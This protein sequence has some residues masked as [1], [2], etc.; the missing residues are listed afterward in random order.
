MTGIRYFVL[1]QSSAP[2]PPAA[3]LSPQQARDQ[4]REQ[5]RQSVEDGVR[6]SQ[7]GAR[8]GEIVRIGPDGH[9]TVTPRQGPP[10]TIEPDHP[11]TFGGPGDGIPPEA[12]DMAMGFF[13]MCAV[14]VVG[15]PIARAFGRRIE[16]SATTPAIQPEVAA[17]LH[18]IEQAVES[19]A[20][21]VERISESQRFV[22]KL[23]SGAQAERV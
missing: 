10:M 14:M 22:A 8:A 18:R 6:A 20:I 19:M 17:Q 9:V 11:A 2:A 15:W 21:E 3:P 4:I 16:R 12:V 23:Q 5:I 13:V 7:E 1:Q